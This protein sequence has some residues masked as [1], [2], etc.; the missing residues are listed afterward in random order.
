[1]ERLYDEYG[2]CLPMT[3]YKQA[4]VLAPTRLV[5]EVPDDLRSIIYK[6]VDFNEKVQSIWP[7]FDCFIK[8]SFFLFRT[9]MTWT[10]KLLSTQRMAKASSKLAK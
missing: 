4:A 6:A 10:C 5:W 8:Y 7:L 3:R 2:R 1:M 9:M